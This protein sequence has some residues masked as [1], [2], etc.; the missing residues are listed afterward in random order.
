MAMSFMVRQYGKTAWQIHNNTASSARK[1]CASSSGISQDNKLYS[2]R[3]YLYMMNLPHRAPHTRLEFAATVASVPRVDLSIA[4]P[5]ALCIRTYTPDEANH[6][7]QN[8]CYLCLYLHVTACIKGIKHIKIHP[9]TTQ[10]ALAR[11]K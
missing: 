7:I 4:R 5:E 2:V 1:P 9:G 6:R 10:N 11:L 8:L 3:N